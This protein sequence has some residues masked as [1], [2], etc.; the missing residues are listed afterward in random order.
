MVDGK[1][2]SAG[3]AGIKSGSEYADSPIIIGDTTDF[4]YK[5][6]QTGKKGN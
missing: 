5:V 4:P 2:A 1:A 3:P 6:Q